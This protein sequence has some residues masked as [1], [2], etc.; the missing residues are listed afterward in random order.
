M[1]ISAVLQLSLVSAREWESLNVRV[2]HWKQKAVRSLSFSAGIETL[3]K[4]RKGYP[5]SNSMPV[6]MLS[7]CVNELETTQG[8]GKKND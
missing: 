8:V 4:T 3:D 7:A 2:D 6:Q 1:A 5:R